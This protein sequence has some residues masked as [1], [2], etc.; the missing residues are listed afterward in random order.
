ME[1][2]AKSGEQV[3]L[4]F[5]KAVLGYPGNV[6]LRSIDIS[7]YKGRFYG[8]VGPNG[9]GKTTLIKSMLGIIKPL[10]GRI[11]QSKK[12]RFGYVPQRESMDELFPLSVWDIVMMSRFSLVGS[13]RLPGKADRERVEKAL[14]DVGIEC[15]KD[16][17]FRRLSGGQ[18]QRT[19]IARALAGEP[20]M[21]VLDE[22]TNGMD[23]GAEKAIMDVIRGLH[24][25]GFTVV[26]ITH[27]INLVA[28]CADF[29]MLI[30]K[31]VHFGPRKE[32]LTARKLSEAYNIGVNI[33]SENGRTL[34]FT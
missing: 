18:K 12:L 8:V 1:K 26:M 25:D 24:R 23:L 5:Q 29:I 15:L 31:G 22:P 2:E 14:H 32:I 30:N 6:V 16:I 33:Y 19:L 21:L 28:D 4:S 9:A 27:L 11:V 10:S 20:D 13:F 34:I 3:M 17:P 7:M